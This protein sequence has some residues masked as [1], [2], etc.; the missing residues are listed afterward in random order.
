MLEVSY[1]RHIQPWGSNQGH[2]IHRGRQGQTVD[3]IV[4]RN[5]DWQHPTS[6]FV[7]SSAPIFVSARTNKRHHRL[8]KS[9]CP[10]LIKRTGGGGVCVK[11]TEKSP[12]F[13]QDQFVKQQWQP[14]GDGRWGRVVG[15][16]GTGRSLGR[17]HDGL[18]RNVYVVVTR[19]LLWDRTGAFVLD[20]D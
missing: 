20:R 14:L 16:G 1:R 17:S 19:L 9:Q 6:R 18:K 5:E 12:D 2:W 10:S 3:N 13:W 15:R 8:L 4:E 7:W 11:S